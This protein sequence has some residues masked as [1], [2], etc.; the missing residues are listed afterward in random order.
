[1]VRRTPLRPEDLGLAEAGVIEERFF[2]AMPRDSYGEWLYVQDLGPSR[3]E[4][5]ARLGSITSRGPGALLCRVAVNTAPWPTIEPAPAPRWRLAAGEWA[6]LV[7]TV[8]MGLRERVSNPYLPLRVSASSASEPEARAAWSATRCRALL[9]R[10][11]AV[12]DMDTHW[13]DQ[14]IEKR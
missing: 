11:E 13:D 2:L 7:C 12:I 4:A 8:D 14:P 6:V 1:M 10:V 9:V 3:A 5:E